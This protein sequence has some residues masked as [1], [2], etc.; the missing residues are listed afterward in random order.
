APGLQFTDPGG[1]PVAGL[2]SIRGVSQ[3]DFAGH[4]EPANAYYIDEIYQP[5]NA[6]SVQRLFDVERVEILKGPQGTLFGRNATGGLLHVIT[7]Q[8]SQTLD[9]FAELTIGSFDQLGFEGALGGPLSDTVS[10][11]ASVFYNRHDGYFENAVGPDIANDDTI[12][13][14]AQVKIEPNDRLDIALFA[15]Y[16]KI[17]PVNSGASLI[18]GAVQDADGLGVALPPGSPTGFGYVDADGDPYTVAMNHQ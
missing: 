10:A 18:T 6:T 4:I 3:N 7:R 15:D 17:R 16:Y 12:A 13:G 1:S 11:R 5:S 14:R 9:G 2:I 8:P